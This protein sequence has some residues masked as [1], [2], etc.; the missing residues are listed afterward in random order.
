MFGVSDVAARLVA[1]GFSLGTVLVTFGL[2]KTLY[3]ATS[4]ALAATFVA[5]SGYSVLLG[6]LALL[7]STLVF[8]FTLSFLC[9]AKWLTT[10]RDMWLYGF[11]AAV[12]ADD[13]VEGHGWAGVGDRAQLPAGLAVS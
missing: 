3:S 2:A 11:A 7:D 5:L 6:R 1:V 12:G 9:F 4:V 10:E 8:F 13:P